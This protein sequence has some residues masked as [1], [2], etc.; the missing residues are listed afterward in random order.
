MKTI[1]TLAFAALLAVFAM[2]PIS[3]LL[4]AS[5]KGTSQDKDVVVLSKN[6]IVV[7]NQEITGESAQLTMEQARKLDVSSYSERVHLTDRKPIYIFLFT[8]GGSVQAG[9]ELLEGLHGLNRPVNTITAFSASMGFQLAQGLGERLILSSGVLMS[10]HATGGTEGEIGG[11]GVAQANSRLG[12][13]E[14]RLKEMDEL[15][16]KRTKGK[17][18]LA[19]YQAAYDHELWLTGSEA[20]AQGYAD[21]VV[22]VKCDK[23]LDGY[24]THEAVVMG[25]IPILYDI[26]N[27]PL[28]TSPVNVRIAINTTKGRMSLSDF[29][30]LD[31]GFG[32]SCIQL[33][34]LD[35]KKVCA[36]DTTL[37]LDKLNAARASFLDGYTNIQNHIIP[38]TVR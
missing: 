29:L 3:P 36:A 25:I 21:K 37:S 4:S 18:T 22:T 33:A 19:S 26:S 17:Q 10:H 16:V 7:L 2:L 24:T 32:A 23:T 9:M 6:N 15:T 11:Q 1:K 31:G 14:R 27:C 34:V 28:N 30:A 5:A 38:L 35:G 12:L 20:V 13:W 8:P